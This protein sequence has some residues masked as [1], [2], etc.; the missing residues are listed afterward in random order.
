MRAIPQLQQY[1]QPQPCLGQGFPCAQVDHPTNLRCP[2]GV[3]AAALW[4][5]AQVDFIGLLR[6]LGFTGPQRLWRWARSSGAWRPRG[7]ELSTYA[8]SGER[9]GLGELL[10]ADFEAM[11]LSALYRISDRCRRRRRRSRTRCS[12]ACRP[13]ARW[14]ATP[15]TPARPLQGETQRLPPGHPGPGAQRQRPRAPFRGLCRQ[16]R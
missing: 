10:G 7:S 11:R 9:S 5:T 4:A 15:R 16:R 14:P 13:R 3:K 12:G 6:E 1:R 2:V 8:W